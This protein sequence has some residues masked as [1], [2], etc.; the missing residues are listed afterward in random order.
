M[1]AGLVSAAGQAATID[2][3]ALHSRPGEPVV[4]SAGERASRISTNGIQIAV[5]HARRAFVDV[6]APGAT[7]AGLAGASVGT[8]CVLT[9]GLWREGT[10]GQEKQKKK[11][12]FN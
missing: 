4:A 5:V 3:R 10:K 1:H 8:L 7:K 2:Q 12:F 11:I 9:H 6:G